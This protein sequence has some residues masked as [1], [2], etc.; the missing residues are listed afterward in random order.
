VT[1]VIADRLAGSKLEKELQS[2]GRPNAWRGTIVRPDWITTCVARKEL[3]PTFEYR[4]VKTGIR[5]I[6]ALLSDSV[7]RKG[8]SPV[9]DRS[10][11]QDR[12]ATASSDDDKIDY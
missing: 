3:V 1:H 2:V 5:N 12:E 9:P 7:S 11:E 4:I 10:I 6:A 8:T